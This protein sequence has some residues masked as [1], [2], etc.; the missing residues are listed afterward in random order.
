MLNQNHFIYESSVAFEIVV[1]ICTRRVLG[2][3]VLFASQTFHIE[4][5]GD[6]LFTNAESNICRSISRNNG[7]RV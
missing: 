1:A 4:S 7:A 6:R 3:A 5:K 2:D